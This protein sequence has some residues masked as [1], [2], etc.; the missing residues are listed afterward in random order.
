MKI[1]FTFI[2]LILI[3]L[4]AKDS[5][6]EKP[7]ISAQSAILIDAKSKRVLAS[8]NP[9]IK[10]PIASTTKIMTALVA[11]G[12][13]ELTDKVEIDNRSVG[14]EG[15][16]IYLEKGEI[17]TLE[18][19]LYGLLLRSGNDSAMAIANFLGEYQEKYV[20]M[21]NEEAKKIGAEST[22]F[23]NPHG[24][25]QDKHYS[26]A[27]DLALITG[28][29]MKIDKFKEIVSS[30]SWIANRSKNSIFYNKNKAL[31]E[32]EGG[33]GVKTGYTTKSGRCLVTTA[34][35]DDTQLIAV[36]L[37]D[38]NWFNDC[39]K[40]MDYGFENFNTYVICEKEQFLKNIPIYNGKKDYISAISKDTFLY[41]LREE[42]IERI[43]INMSLP[44]TIEAPVI[45]GEKIGDII[46]YLDGQIIHKGE[47]IS[48]EN[49]EKLSIIR[50]FFKK[51]RNQ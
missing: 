12:K 16:S 40:L 30:K 22:N 49:V 17:I 3:L 37:N 5:Y 38:N 20:K 24:L 31:W 1:K 45:K 7:G 41:P 29:A 47:I 26:T 43:K 10:L 48:K 33:D 9:Y 46:I 21:M 28:E 15:S 2:I 4:P 23:T 14:I 36:V 19:L 44:E 18:D 6:C 39:Y 8:Y 42:E 32:Y 11:L 50:N 34:T 25:H 13:G 27:Y 35:R 51:I